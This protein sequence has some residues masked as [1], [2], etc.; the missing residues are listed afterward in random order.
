MMAQESKPFTPRRVS[1][2]QACLSRQLAMPQRFAFLRDNEPGELHLRLL[3]PLPPPAEETISAWSCQAGLLFLEQAGPLLSM[4]GTCPAIVPSSAAETQD[5]H[6]YWALYNHY[7]SPQLR[8]WLGE[9]RPAS[10][11]HCGIPAN[12]LT[13]WLT[14]SCGGQHL[15][16][17]LWASADTLQQWLAAPGWQHTYAPLPGHLAIRLPLTLAEVTLS[18]ENL[19]SLEPGDVICPL[20]AYFSVHGNGSITLAGWRLSGQLTL[21]GLAPYRF[22]VT[23]L[24]EC[25]VTTPFDDPS[26]F[27]DFPSASAPYA[28]ADEA[29]DGSSHAAHSGYVAALAPLSLALTVRCG[30]L[31]LTLQDLQQLAPGSVLILQQALPGEAALYH[32]EQPLAHGELVEV[33][34]RLALQITRSLSSV[35][36]APYQAPAS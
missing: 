18:H 3:P 12:A 6:G 2:S 1:R 4:L 17:R 14:V 19:Q 29:P 10:G 36:C 16:C 35:V 8:D 30:Y 24:E 32:G 9:I 11:H 34:G 21:D 26:D 23:A 25:P 5:A 27:T 28:M 7:L 13:L 33:E 20:K 22:T 31:T 15:G